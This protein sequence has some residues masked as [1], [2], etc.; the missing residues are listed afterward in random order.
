MATPSYGPG[1]KNARLPVV[2]CKSVS[3][4]IHQCLLICLLGIFPVAF[5][6][7]DLSQVLGLSWLYFMQKLSIHLAKT[8][9][10]YDPKTFN[11]YTLMVTDH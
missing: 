9:C 8:F 7:K 1:S 10:E 2:N 6:M 4:M 3:H 5:F 11:R